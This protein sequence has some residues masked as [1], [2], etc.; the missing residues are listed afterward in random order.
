M[1]ELD[2]ASPERITGYMAFLRDYADDSTQHKINLNRVLNRFVSGLYSF[3]SVDGEFEVGDVYDPL[4]KVPLEFWAGSLSK[5]LK[6]FVFASDLLNC[7]LFGNTRK[8]LFQFVEVSSDSKDAYGDTEYWMESSKLCFDRELSF[9]ELVR[10]AIEQSGRD[11]DHNIMADDVSTEL[12][13]SKDDIVLTAKK[14]KLLMTSG[15]RAKLAAD[16]L[17]FETRFIAVGDETEIISFS[18]DA[19]L[20]ASGSR[21]ILKSYGDYSKI[22]VSNYSKVISK[23]YR[24]SINVIGDF[25]QINVVGDCCSCFAKGKNNYINISGMDGKVKGIEGTKVQIANY[26][27]AHERQDDLFA[28]IG[29]NNVKPDTWYTV[30][31]GNFVDWEC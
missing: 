27:S 19:I 9:E 21:S 1:S 4:V 25:A 30:K 28:I 18:E 24:D 26:N 2:T 10:V 11:I 22:V 3:S 29:E 14:A 12:A 31:S 6:Y 20:I 16:P 23:G 7:D 17:S 13:S 15:K 5:L 8:N